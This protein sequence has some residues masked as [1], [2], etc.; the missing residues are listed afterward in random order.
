MLI[1]KFDIFLLTMG[2]KKNKHENRSDV[3]KAT[4]FLWS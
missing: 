1:E 4:Y 3:G 2:M